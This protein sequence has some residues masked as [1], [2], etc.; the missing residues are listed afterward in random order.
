MGYEM[1]ETKVGE[2]KTKGENLCY[3][4]D[5]GGWGKEIGESTLPL[6]ASLIC[7]WILCRDLTDIIRLK[8]CKSYVNVKLYL[9]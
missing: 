7:P 3:K 2:I 1:G 6:S 8:S 9:T 5:M 4:V